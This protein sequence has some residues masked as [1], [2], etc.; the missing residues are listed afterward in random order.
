MVCEVCHDTGM[1]EVETLPEPQPCL[2]CDRGKEIWW[3]QAVV[4]T[5]IVTQ[6]STRQEV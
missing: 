4:T 3:S 2:W 6:Q 5:R 1:V